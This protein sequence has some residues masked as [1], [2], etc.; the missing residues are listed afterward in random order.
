MKC[1]YSILNGIQ[2]EGDPIDNIYCKEENEEILLLNCAIKDKAGI[3]NWKRIFIREEAQRD[4]Q[5]D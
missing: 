4:I 5:V 1:V 3:E 2:H